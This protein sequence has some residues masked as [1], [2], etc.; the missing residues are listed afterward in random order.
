MSKRW[1][2]AKGYTYET[3]VKD[4]GYE[5]L[6]KALALEPGEVIDTVKKCNL[7]GRGGAGF[8]A[9]IKWSF[10]PKEAEKPK[11]LV[12]NGDESEPGT[13]KDR[14]VLSRDPHMVIEGAAIAAYAIGAH[15][16]YFYLRGEFGLPRRRLEA[17]VAE[18]YDKGILGDSVLG[19]PYKLNAAVHRGAGAYICGEETALLESLEGKIGRPRLKPPFPA[20]VGAF[21][22]PTIVNN[23]ET[24]SCVPLI[25]TR[26][27]DWF[28]S[29]GSAKNGGPK[30]ICLSGHV[31]RP[32]VYEV[33]NGFP[34]NKLIELAGGV[35]K[36]R[37]LKAVIPGGSSTPLL[38]PHACQALAAEGAP[39]SDWPLE[40]DT[41]LD[42][43]SVARAGS[44][45]G[46]AGMIVLDENTCMVRTLAILGNFYAHE[47]CGQCTPCREGTGWNTK[48]LWRLERGEATEDD[49]DTINSASSHMLGMTI[50]PLADAFAMPVQSYLKKFREEFVEH[51]RRKGC[52]FPP[53]ELSPHGDPFWED[54][55]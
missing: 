49:I 18:A 22:G 5:G 43:D 19:K 50:C 40:T 48:M 7:R 31:E 23:V 38:V 14:Y 10:V 11:Y 47:S 25:F 51:V 21:G 53:F 15:Q 41:P 4:G 42:F 34:C 17:A 16:I 27:V 36:G 44:M 24:L 55:P 12:V 35:W 52:W 28:L 45:F 13:Y 39:E 30:I 20:V 33:P 8:P 32:G 29:M 46:S 2:V 3:Y 54:T 9:G 26:G 1:F 37:K 6:K